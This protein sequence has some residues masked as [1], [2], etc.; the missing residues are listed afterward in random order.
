M[1]AHLAIGLA[2]LALLTATSAP[3]EVQ[4]TDRDIRLNDLAIVDP[5][6]QN[7]VIARLPKGTNQLELDAK[8]ARR[9]IRNRLPAARAQL[10]FVDSVT[11]VAPPSVPIR[12]TGRCFVAAERIAKGEF[13]TAALVE[14]AACDTESSRAQIGYDR[15]ASA[16]IAAE[17]IAAGANLGPVRPVAANR[18]TKGAN[19]QLVT[20]TGP[21]TISRSAT[22]L[23]P[24]REGRNV[25]IRTSDGEVFPVPVS[26]IEEDQAQ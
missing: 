10:S 16:P 21:V 18:I 24:A 13:I 5:D 23:Q 8:S 12:R 9:L 19:V 2:S 11:F 26:H 7:P 22:T 4:L 14:E 6:G 15:D 3:S 17:D 20:G 1:F 25:F